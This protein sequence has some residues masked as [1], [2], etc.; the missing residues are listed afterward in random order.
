LVGGGFASRSKG[1]QESL[2]P[3]I[4]IIIIII[5]A[6]IASWEGEYLYD[7]LSPHVFQYLSLHVFLL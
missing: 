2:P 5:I 4:I 1:F 3:P 6:L 7:Q